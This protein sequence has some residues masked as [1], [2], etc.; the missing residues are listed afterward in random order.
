MVE[1]KTDNFIGRKIR[2]ANL[3]LLI[4]NLVLFTVAGL[5]AIFLIHLLYTGAQ[6]PPPQQIPTA[7]FGFEL[8][9]NL[10]LM[11]VLAASLW[12]CYLGITSIRTA[13]AR[14]SDIS[15]NT[16]Y[17][18]LCQYGD[19][20]ERATEVEAERAPQAKRFVSPPAK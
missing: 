19:P 8:Y 12:F 14:L 13:M 17:K 4:S 7:L 2:S 10:V 11:L 15:K 16:A 9:V 20:T 3:G 6:A 18:Q 1:F 5:T